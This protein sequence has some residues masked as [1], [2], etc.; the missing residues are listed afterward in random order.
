MTELTNLKAREARV[1]RAACQQGLWLMKYRG[2]NPDDWRFG[3]Y[4][5]VDRNNITVYSD[6]VG[7]GFGL[8]LDEVADYLAE[9][10]Q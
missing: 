4:Q 3:T 1:R 9:A 8:T 2:R 6:G 10:E 7:H 5:L